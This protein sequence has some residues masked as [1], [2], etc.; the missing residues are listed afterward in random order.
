MPDKVDKTDKHESTL[1][2]IVKSVQNVAAPITTPIKKVQKSFLR[3]I[4]KI[5]LY[6]LELLILF[7]IILFFFIQTH[8]FNQL[9]LN[10]AFGKLNDAWKEKESSVYAESIRG[11]IFRGYRLMNGGIIVKSD[12]LMKFDTLSFRYNLLS[13]LNDKIVVNRVNIQNPVLNISKVLNKKNEPVWNFAYLLSSEKKE[14]DTAKKP[15]NW[16][17]EVED[18]RIN[19]GHFRILDT[20]L[21]GKTLNS[22]NV[23]NTKSC[24]PGNMNITGF[25][26]DIDA[27]YYPDFKSVT[28][29]NLSFN[30]NSEFEL[31]KFAISAVV[32]P[33]DSL[34]E[35]KD[36]NIVTP[37]TE[38]VAP[39]I[40][41]TNF[42]PFEGV[43][44]FDFKN[45][46]VKLD[47]NAK[48]FNFADLIYFLPGIKFLNGVLSLEINAD[49]KYGDLNVKKLILKTSQS[50]LNVSG[51]V[52]NLHDPGKLY[53]DVT[54]KDISLDPADT[55]YLLPGIPIPD[56]G[57]VGKVSGGFSYTGEPLDFASDF[58]LQTGMGGAKG[59]FSINLKN[60]IPSY[61]T[62]VL[63]NNLNIGGILKNKDLESSINIKADVSGSGFDIN[64]LSA[65]V[66]YELVN[67]KFY[68]FNI[69]KSAG[70][71]EL[72]GNNVNADLSV[73]T[74]ELDASLKGRLNLG[75][76]DDAEYSLKGKAHN[77]DIS[78][79][80]KKQTDRSNLNLVFDVN[81]K[82]A[83]LE[84]IEG[85]YDLAF[86]NSSYSSYF[87]PATPVDMNISK[88]GPDVDLSVNSNF[89]DLKAK[90]RFDLKDIADVTGYHLTILLNEIQRKVARDTT[91][92]IFSEVLPPKNLHD[93]NINYE[94]TTKDINPLTKLFDSA[95]IKFDGGIKGSMSN[96]AEQF[97]SSTELNIRNFNYLDSLF[98]VKNL[99]GKIEMGDVYKNAELRPFDPLY[100]VTAN[101]DLK[102]DR[103]RIAGT[104]FDSLAL[105]LDMAKSIQQFNIRGGLDSTFIINFAGNSYVNNW[106]HVTFD[107][108]FIKYNN[109]LIKN[110]G[111]LVVNY[112]PDPSRKTISFK[113]FNIQNNLMDFSVSGDLSLAGKSNLD[114]E[115]D[116]IKIAEIMDLLFPPDT[117]SNKFAESRY[118]SPIKGMIR[119]INI[120]FEGEKSDPTLGIQLSSDL[121][122]YK[123]IAIGRI[124]TFAVNFS[125]S[126]LS[127]QVLVSNALENGRL[128]LQ[129]D[130]PLVNPF[131]KGE[132]RKEISIADYPVNFDLNA[133]NFQL[134]FFSKLIP[135]IA[136]IRG[137]ANGDITVTG[138]VSEPVLN[139]GMDIT[140][141]RFLL[142]ITGLYHRFSAKLRADKSDLIVDD[143]RIFNLENNYRHIDFSGKVSFEGLSVKNIDLTSSGD[144]VVLDE[145]AQENSFGMTGTMI[146]GSGDPPLH[147]H[148]DLDRIY[149][150][151]QLLIK[152]ANLKFSSVPTS[153]YDVSS[154]NFVYRILKDTSANGFKDTVIIVQPEKF[155]EVDPFLRA[156]IDTSSIQK[157]KKSETN[158][159]YN[160]NVKTLKNA[161]ISVVF[162]TLTS[163]E[164][165][166]EMQSDLYLS[167]LNNGSL[168]I[169]GNVD[170]VG[171]SYYRYYRNF[172]V[173]DSKLVFRG[174]ADNPD[175]NISAV[176]EIKSVSQNS[177]L[178]TNETQG[179]QIVLNITG[180]KKNPKLVLTLIENGEEKTGN[181][182]QA[183][184]ISYLL[185]GVSKN[186]L[187]AGQEASI[188]RNFGA[189]TGS[190]I[191]SAL[192]GNAIRNIAPFILNAELNYSGENLQTG[193]DIR[194]TSSVGDAIVK[195]GGK[196]FSG[197]ENTEIN[198]EYPL[199]RL[200]NMNISNNLVVEFSRLID[201]SGVNGGR[202]VYTGVKLSYKLMY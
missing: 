126:V 113:Q 85:K 177:F 73:S 172:K 24:D 154:D 71:V 11:N 105:K 163:E 41:L 200:L 26:L 144:L 60:A 194:I 186:S 191:L 5:I 59:N 106:L 198:V 21:S 107:T 173:K 56:Y 28:V 149:I 174:P 131:S 78:K 150:D 115:A 104:A 151:G 120:H 184:A 118:K 58:D 136:D 44:Y 83:S 165:Y 158:V 93:F 40:A 45:Y 130:I 8:T 146:V 102:G 95:G 99:K 178:S 129:G 166:G 37:R 101:I 138:T 70:V 121:L 100:P 84:N 117:T 75:K 137:F 180:S 155:D 187:S 17:I 143:F 145:S 169:N 147:I 29:K 135:N 74:D 49:G 7:L 16:G 36:M 192:L 140:N 79:I 190:N 10:F 171:D 168:E 61:K 52:K 142:G 202:S 103:V 160:I 23:T 12:T 134:N 141:G 43:D 82:G 98:D 133:N 9:A 157:N 64:K 18:L 181:D 57:Y 90:G 193:T 31:K 13:L 124:D 86:Q 201:E 77:F 80:T 14:I 153:P 116:S 91:G 112:I 53:F 81:G 19:N 39:L 108:L 2:P 15:F 175:L 128:R 4:P 195:V 20:N 185:F 176:Y 114:V 199:N 123:N 48:K 139:G 1:T 152:D 109:F 92:V 66:N 197:I 170:I 35:I 96:N 87:I 69:S 54:A 196:V 125:K 156:Y 89:F 179:I 51:K 132:G 47:F 55:K 34:A 72:T 183:D 122:K 148:G 94:F 50:T 159:T 110:S 33:K 22:I 162:N 30:T 76:P 167:N 67:S 25:N 164:L 97:R 65:K 6:P 46:A 119:R 88:S 111:D 3:H 161:I 38:I 42:N 127:T 27:K 68:N 63:T 32:S 189:S 62:T 182:A 188:A